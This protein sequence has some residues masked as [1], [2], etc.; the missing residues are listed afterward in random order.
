ML[1]AAPLVP[2]EEEDPRLLDYYIFGG[3]VFVSLSEPYLA[4]TFGKKWKRELCQVRS[5]V[6]NFE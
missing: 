4:E 1:P 2:S 6:N 3:L 5:E